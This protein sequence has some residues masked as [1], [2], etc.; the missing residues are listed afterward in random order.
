MIILISK[1]NIR[2]EREVKENSLSWH[3]CS[4]MADI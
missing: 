2:E 4:S 1:I 3:W